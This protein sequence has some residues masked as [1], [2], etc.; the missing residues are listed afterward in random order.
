MVASGSLGAPAACFCKHLRP[1][2]NSTRKDI[3]INLQPSLEYCSPACPSGAALG[4]PV[5]PRALRVATRLLS[6]L[7]VLPIGPRALRL[8]GC[9]RG[10][11][12]V[13]APAALSAR[14]GWSMWT[15]G[16][17]LMLREGRRPGRH[18]GRPGR[19]RC[20]GALRVRY[21]VTRQLGEGRAD[22]SRRPASLLALVGV[23]LRRERRERREQ[24][25]DQGVHAPGLASAHRTGSRGRPGPGPPLDPGGRSERHRPHRLGAA[26]PARHARSAPGTT[27]PPR[28]PARPALVGL[29]GRLRRRHLCGRGIPAHPRDRHSRHGRPDR[30]RS[31]ARLA[32]GRP[33]RAAAPA[34]AA[35]H[36][37]T[38]GPCRTPARGVALVQ[39]T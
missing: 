4:L 32:H 5:W 30:R 17:T 19:R 10:L 1:N 14:V 35:P 36:P 25:V 26:R 29:A 13:E 22:L 37:D 7:R 23:Q 11:V 28:S 24:H 20:P 38:P 18:R 12:G 34:Q 16:S 33:A 9:G 2:S 27:A 6:S 3:W 39:L 8:C 15:A 21:A 31:A